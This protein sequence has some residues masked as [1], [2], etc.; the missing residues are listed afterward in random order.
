MMNIFAMS[1]SKKEVKD[2]ILSVS[3]VLAEHL[4]KVT[5]MPDSPNVSHWEDEI[6]RFLNRVPRMKVSNKYPS[7][8][9][10]LRWISSDNDILDNIIWQVC[11]DYKLDNDICNVACAFTIVSEYQEWL[12]KHLSN[13]GAVTRNMVHQFLDKEIKKF[14]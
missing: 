1:H 2:N 12:S 13:T 10:L 11:S 5:L 7:Y 9:S 14:L 4:V 8:N 6:Y 3:D